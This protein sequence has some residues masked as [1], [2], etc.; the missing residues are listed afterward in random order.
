MVQTEPFAEA[1]FRWEES[2]DEASER[3]EHEGNLVLLEFYSPT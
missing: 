1:L 3:A 2:L